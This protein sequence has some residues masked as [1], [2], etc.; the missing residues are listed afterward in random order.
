MI[1]NQQQ[2]QPYTRT[3]SSQNNTFITTHSNHPIPL[4]C[5]RAPTPLQQLCRSSETTC[6]TPE[7]NLVL[8]TTTWATCRCHQ[9]H[10][11]VANR[12]DFDMCQYQ[13]DSSL[14]TDN[15]NSMYNIL[16]FNANGYSSSKRIVKKKTAILWL[17]SDILRITNTFKNDF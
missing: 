9:P 8:L 11:P 15:L 14:S 3:T 4:P 7:P 5:T 13:L 10:W 1:T 2:Q 17:N 12:H 6:W 16:W